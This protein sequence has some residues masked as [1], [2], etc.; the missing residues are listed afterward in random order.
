MVNG[1]TSDIVRL[2]GVGTAALLFLV[3]CPWPFGDLSDAS[4]PSTSLS[5]LEPIYVGGPAPI[6]A[7][8][9]L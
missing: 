9:E 3:G 5:A 8:V 6:G 4:P 1:A 2:R 7:E